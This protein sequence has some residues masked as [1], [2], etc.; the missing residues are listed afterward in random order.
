[1]RVVKKTGY[2]AAQSLGASFNGPAIDCGSLENLFFEFSWTGTPTGTIVLQASAD[3]L[4]WI[5][6]STMA[7]PAG[8]ASAG[9]NEQ[10]AIG[11]AFCRVAYTFT[12]GAGT[13]TVNYSGKGNAP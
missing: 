11:Y 5:N 4:T 12:S 3:G 8:S 13:L 7:A 6:I 9:F 1:M 2:L 10:K